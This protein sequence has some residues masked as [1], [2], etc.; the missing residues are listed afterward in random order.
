MAITKPV[1]SAEQAGTTGT[2]AAAGTANTDI[3]LATNGWDVVVGL[4]DVTL[5]SSSGVTVRFFRSTD[6]GASFSDESLA[7]GFTV[8]ADG[9]YPFDLYAED[10]TRVSILNDDGAN[11]TGTI[12]VNYQGR[13]W[14]TL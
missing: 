14:E 2:I 5:G 12:T 1:W 4:I 13:N 10:Y 9:V 3:D 8:T 11:A 7:G 6:S